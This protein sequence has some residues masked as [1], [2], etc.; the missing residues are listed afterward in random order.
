MADQRGPGVDVELSSVSFSVKN[1]GEIPISYDEIEVEF[2][3]TT[4]TDSPYGTNSLQPGAQAPES[5]YFSDGI[6][7]KP[8]DYEITIRVLND[9]DVV[10]SGSTAVSTST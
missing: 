1:T 8:G 9:G 10:A 6:S 3:G 2:G 7:V 4:R 5:V